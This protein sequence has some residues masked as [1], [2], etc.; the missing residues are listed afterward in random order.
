M[1]ILSG[2]CWCVASPSVQRLHVC[3][4]VYPS[5]RSAHRHM[6]LH[7]RLSNQVTQKCLWLC[8]FASVH[9]GGDVWNH[10]AGEVLQLQQEGP[11]PVG[12]QLQ[13][14]R[15]RVQTQ[16]HAHAHV[17]QQGDVRLR[18]AALISVRKKPWQ[19]FLFPVAKMI[20][21]SVYLK[22]LVLFFF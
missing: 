20:S 17:G 11:L 6:I 15:V 18:A 2:L 16:R 5:V 21:S 7:V 9:G 4:C 22:F 10:V 3:A 12:Q 13:Q 19:H 8:V 14:H 1:L